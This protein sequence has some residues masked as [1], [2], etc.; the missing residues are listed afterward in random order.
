MG[1]IRLERCGWF[2]W[3]FPDLEYQIDRANSALGCFCELRFAHFL[4]LVVL[5]RKNEQFVAGPLPKQG[6]SLILCV[7]LAAMIIF[8]PLERNNDKKWCLI[9][10]DLRKSVLHNRILN[11]L[12]LIYMYMYCQSFNDAQYGLRILDCNSFSF[13]YWYLCVVIFFL[14][15]L[16]QQIFFQSLKTFL[17]LLILSWVRVLM[18]LVAPKHPSYCSKKFMTCLFLAIADDLT[19]ADWY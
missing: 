16:F 6:K 1:E 10:V 3:F 12:S 4:L 11:S 2:T 9:E 19:T 13:P 5:R 18:V 15:G 8:A 17:S 14:W 7:L